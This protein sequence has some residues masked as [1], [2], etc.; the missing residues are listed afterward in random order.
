MVANEFRRLGGVDGQYL[1]A[2]SAVSVIENLFAD[3]EVQVHAPGPH[4]L[5]G[6]YPVKVGTGRVLLDL[7][8]GVTREVAISINETGQRRDG[9][10]A[11]LADGTVVFAREQMNIMDQLLGYFMPD[12]GVRD[13][14]QCAH[15]LGCKYRFFVDHIGKQGGSHHAIQER[16]FVRRFG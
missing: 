2:M 16:P 8:F 11:I 15:E 7:P 5:P 9:I 10:Q 6:G 13:A 12:M 1:T 14:A 3:H 4:G